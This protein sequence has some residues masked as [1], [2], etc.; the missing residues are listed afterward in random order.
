[1][2]NDKYQL[3]IQNIQHYF[4]ESQTSIHK[5]RNE[6]KIINFN[7]E[8]LVIKSFKVPNILNKIVYTFF[9]DSKSKKSYNNSIKI[10]QFV[11][12]PIAFIELKKFG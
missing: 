4:N 7:D 2:I 8:E 11:P 3:L 10:T 9:R 5:A 1:M 6:I 12:A